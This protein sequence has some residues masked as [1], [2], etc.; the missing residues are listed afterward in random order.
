[1]LFCLFTPTDADLRDACF[2]AG[3]NSKMMFGLV[4]R[5]AEPKNKAANTGKLRSDQLAALE[6][7]HRSSERKDTIGAEYFSGD[8]VPEGFEAELQLFPGEKYPGYPPVIIHH[9]FIV[10]DA[11]TE[12]PIIYTGSAN[13][14]ENSVH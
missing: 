14:S 9:K 4:N 13:M 10:I 8:A 1:M 11:E 3:D 6:L 5:I 2:A 12:N 7:Y